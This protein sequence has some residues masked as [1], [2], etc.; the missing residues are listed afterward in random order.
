M[1]VFKLTGW[2]TDTERKCKELTEELNRKYDS[3]LKRLMNVHRDGI[4]IKVNE[5]EI[6]ILANNIK[7]HTFHGET[8]LKSLDKAIKCMV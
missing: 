6:S 4:R 5:E 3:E 8:A 7:I 1:E 2:A